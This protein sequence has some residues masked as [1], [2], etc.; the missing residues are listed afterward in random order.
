M[1]G[2]SEPKPNTNAAVKQH[3]SAL[4]V[5]LVV[6]IAGFGLNEGHAHSM[7]QS[8]VLLDI[9]D[10][11]IKAELQLPIDRLSISFRQ[12]V[13]QAHLPAAAA[14]LGRYLQ[15]HVHPATADGKAFAVRVEQVYIK[16]VEN[17]PYLVAQL[18]LT[19]PGRQ[20]PDR[21]KLNYDVI[22]HEIVTHVVLV[23]IRR[24]PKSNIKPED[25]QLIG[26][27]RG[28]V[29]SVDVIRGKRT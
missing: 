17:A 9:S 29:Q 19:P 13:D 12:T 27:I 18:V 28:D 5:S 10:D 20:T 7:Y 21:F 25:P 14:E 2:T 1:P 8:A 16:T 6:L 24:D 11:V 26:I 4:T 22:A 15:S 3:R 23:S